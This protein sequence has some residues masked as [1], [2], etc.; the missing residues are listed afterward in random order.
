MSNLL[1]R[2]YKNQG[3]IYKVLLCIASTILIV[4]LFPK[5]GKFQFDF[6]Q[7]KPWQY[8]NL[9]APVDFA[10]LKSDDQLE[11]E[12]AEARDNIIPYFN[13]DQDIANEAKA[14]YENQF[15]SVFT[16]SIFKNRQKELKTFGRQIL[17]DIYK[18][19]VISD[20][21]AFED[22]RKIYLR[23]GNEIEETSIENLNTTDEITTLINRRLVNGPYVQAVNRFK[24]LFYD[25]VQANVFYDEKLT[26][27]ELNA[28]LSKIAPTKGVVNKGSRIVAK[29]EIVEQKTYQV[30]KSLQAEYE[31]QTW[32]ASKYNWVVFGYVL[33]V[34]VALSMLL[35]FIRNYREQ[36]FENNTKVTFIF[37]NIILMVLFTTLIVKY[38]ANYVYVVPLC[39]LPLVIKAFF[40]ARLGLFTHVI[41][42]LLL[43]FIVPNTSEYMFLQVIAGIVTILTVSELYKRANLFISVGQITFIYI[44][45][46]FAFHIIHEGTIDNLEWET[47]STFIITGLA[48]LFV[49]PLIYAY[50]KI[51]GLVSDLSLLEL[52]DTNSKLLKELANKAPGTFHHSLNVANLAEAAANEIGANSMLV[53]VG[54]LYHDIGK[55]VNPTDFTENQSTGINTHEDLSPD[56]SA[57]IIIDHVLNGIEIARK[58]N[59]PDRVIDFIRTHHGTSTVYYFYKKA[60]EQD[61]E[62]NIEDFKY[63][64]PL[65]F[66]KETAILMMSDSVEAASKSLKNPTSVLIDSFV[67][68]I[69]NKQMDEN[70]FLNANITFKE[71]Q[72]IKKV[73]KLKLNNIYHL[74]IEYPE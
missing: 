67:E 50:E 62:V 59:L 65:P 23:R 70:Q 27:K 38:D 61:G 39:I 45:G 18:Y 26:T 52:T 69:I 74:R 54:A 51:F 53:R 35:L 9:Y 15:A 72:T 41:A 20:L 12:R 8:D 3:S 66:S 22:G 17:D 33:L 2:F 34:S 11:K 63:P 48:T 31:S 46:Y 14:A 6:Q 7:N 1:N 37:F 47:F 49:Q 55:M 68:K 4:Y 43:G 24:E 44:L 29:G 64:G 19:G 16:D 5:S 10:I 57:R 56:E 58:N 42:I 13:Y 32:T 21:T 40:D 28:E 71:I 36:V 73:L 30:L 25:I 60:Q